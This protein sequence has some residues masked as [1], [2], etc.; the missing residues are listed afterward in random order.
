MR[1][2]GVGYDGLGTLCGTALVFAGQIHHRVLVNRESETRIANDLGISRITIR[3]I[4]RILK[5]VGGVPSAERLALI[6][7][8]IPDATDEDIGEWFG[9]GHVWAARVR[10]NAEAIR[11]REQIPKVMEVIAGEADDDMPSVQER[12]AIAAEIRRKGLAAQKEEEPPRVTVAQY[13][14]SSK[15]GSFVSVGS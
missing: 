8:R 4:L 5:Y 14:W 10:A 13:A 6:A 1:R 11:E 7:M 3:S 15:H 12:E 9:H 2:R